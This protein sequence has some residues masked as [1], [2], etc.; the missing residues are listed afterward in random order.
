[1]V[2]ALIAKLFFRQIIGHSRSPFISCSD[3]VTTIATYFDMSTAIAER[4]AETA[5]DSIH[6][7]IFRVSTMVEVGFLN[8]KEKSVSITDPDHRPDD[9]TYL[10]FRTT[11]NPSLVDTRSPDTVHLFEFSL[12]L[13]NTSPSLSASRLLGNS[14]QPN[15]TPVLV[16]TI[17]L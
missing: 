13:P 16:D 4:E 14:I 3:L 1:M 10:T 15:T 5:A 7:S 8:S 6:D 9:I 12:R 17:F 11:I 2:K